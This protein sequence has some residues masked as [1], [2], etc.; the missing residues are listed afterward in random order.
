MQKINLLYDREGAENDARKNDKKPAPQK[1]SHTVAPR[2]VP[3][4]AP[5]LPSKPQQTFQQKPQPIKNALKPKT[6]RVQKGPATETLGVNLM[7]EEMLA[8]ATQQNKVAALGLVALGCV[9][10]VAAA[11]VGLTVFQQRIVDQIADKEQQIAAI[12]RELVPL[13]PKKQAVAAFQKNISNIL[14]LLSTHLYWTKFFSGLEKYTVRSVYFTGMNADQSG[15]MTLGAQAADYAS[16][17]RQLI[18]FESADD[19]VKDVSIT[20]ANMSE[21]GGRSTVSFS[22]TI[23]LADNV[24]FRDAAG[25][26]LYRQ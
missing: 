25:G 19:F 13:A 26:P 4:P 16:V 9:V 20:S 21:A 8:G 1:Q 5:V 17:A 12:E 24:F 15:R 18:A 7:T 14:N 6:K 3:K 11:Y 10:V 22:V 23:T 2:P